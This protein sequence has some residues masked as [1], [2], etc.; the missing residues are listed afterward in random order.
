[1]DSKPMGYI[2]TRMRL[3]MPALGMNFQSDGMLY[4]TLFKT[5]ECIYPTKA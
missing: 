3:R 5:P 1:M 2:C 4:D